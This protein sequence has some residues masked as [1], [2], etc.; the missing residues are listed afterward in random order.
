[1]GTRTGLYMMRFL[2]W[3]ISGVY[4]WLKKQ[5]FYTTWFVAYIFCMTLIVMLIWL[6]WLYIIYKGGW[7]TRINNQRQG[8]SICDQ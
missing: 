3:Y 4:N 2:I 5:N 6:W 7:Q 1:M 8:V